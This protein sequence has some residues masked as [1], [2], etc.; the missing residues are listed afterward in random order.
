MISQ[1][2][3][4]GLM[5]LLIKLLLHLE[6][7]GVENI[8][9]TGPA[10]IIINHI[11][12]LDPVI[13]CAASP[14]VVI[15]MAKKEAF[16]SILL[17]LFMKGFGAIPVQRGAADTQAVKS[18]L[19]VLQH[20]GVILVAPEGTRSPT[21]QM[22]RGKEGAVML[23]L[24]TRAWL[25][26][27]G[28]TGTQGIRAF[29]TRLKRAPIRLSIGQPFRLRSISDNGRP[30]RAEMS[31]MTEEA[32]YR[33]ARQLPAEFRG[34]YS[35]LDKATEVYVIPFGNESVKEP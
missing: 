8:P 21:C 3:L 16:D 34:V 10:I 28:I 4:L 9:A 7:T 20:N 22:Q 24:R 13:V 25:V 32:M 26:P 17:G 2:I 5:R 11:A 1:K 30:S 6:V 31:A 33:L 29:W 14:R 23:A 18:A 15:P 27:V 19:W 35:H 12:F